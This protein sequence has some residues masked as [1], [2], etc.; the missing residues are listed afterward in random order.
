MAKEQAPEKKELTR[1]H[2]V[3]SYVLAAFLLIVC[4]GMGV[5]TVVPNLGD[6]YQSLRWHKMMAFLP[7]P[8]AA[9]VPFLTQLTARVRSLDAELSSSAYLAD[10]LGQM[11][12][13]LQYAIGKRLVST[14]SAQ[15]VKLN[16]GYLYDIQEEQDLTD[17]VNE[18]VD[19]A[20]EISAERPFLFVYEHPTVYDQ[21]MLPAGY[22]VLDFGEEAAD[23]AVS[24]LQEGNVPLID[25]REVVTRGEYPLADFLLYTDQHWTTFASLVMAEEIALWAQDQG[26]D[27]DPALLDPDTFEREVYPNLFLGKYGQRIGT[28][29]IEPDDITVWYPSYETEITRYT[30]KGK[31][32]FEVTG[33]FRTAAVRW[34]MME[35]NEDG[36]N[37]KAYT[38][39]GLTEKFEHFTNPSAPDITIVLFK[40]S[41]AAPTG[42]F[43]SLTARNV[44]CV[45]LRQGDLGAMDYIEMYDPDL[46]VMAYSQQMLRDRDYAFVN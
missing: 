44:Y 37:I 27:I 18:I 36:W 20:H 42:A 9:E 35:P 8:D 2:R 23:Q 4:F 29:N 13:S 16:G 46:V 14:G 33:D 24:I 41:Y 45:D 32:E 19:L 31:K 17:T 25:S 11:N 1:L 34:D 22:D 43:L 40:D 12:A 7:D 21:A 10:E 15:M 5:M 3:L 26:I 38:N 6:L 28:L 39:Y 30:Q